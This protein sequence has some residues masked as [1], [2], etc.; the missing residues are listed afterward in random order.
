[1][2]VFG[3]LVVVFADHDAT[4]AIT[5]GVNGENACSETILPLVYRHFQGAFHDAVLPPSAA[6]TRLQQRSDAAASIERLV[7]LTAPASERALLTYDIAD[8]AQGITRLRLALEAGSC[9]LQLTDADGEH[10]LEMGVDGWIE[11]D[12]DMP[13]RELHHGYELRPARVV[14]GARWLDPRTL[15]MRWIFAETAFRDK[16]I[17]RFEADRISLAR[18]VNV[19]SGPLSY[20]ALSGRR[21][22]P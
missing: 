8:N 21:V 3:Q 2:G 11:S 9:S 19:N 17:C 10:T 6:E 5:S 14:A 13:G 18:S 12:T 7:S 20:P 16:V 1:M 4:L 15:E 22:A